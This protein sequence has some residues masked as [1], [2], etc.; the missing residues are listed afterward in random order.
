MKNTHTIRIQVVFFSMMDGK[1]VTFLPHHELPTA[2]LGEGISLEEAARKLV[3]ASIGLSTKEG[4]VEQLYTISP[5]KTQTPVVTIVY[6]M[7]LPSH[8]IPVS[9]NHDWV[10]TRDTLKRFPYASTLEY[11]IQRLRWKVEYTNVA[12]SL[13]PNEFVFGEFQRVYEA[14]LGRTV[15]KRNFRKKIFSLNILKDVGKKRVHGR[16]RP[17]ELY[18]FKERKPTIVEI[19]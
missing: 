5:A 12:Y 3:W 7:L 13:L 17:A 18:T 2:E 14:I 1:L 19:L 15:D 10:S 16:A 6:Y 9:K 4:F 8:K 11:A